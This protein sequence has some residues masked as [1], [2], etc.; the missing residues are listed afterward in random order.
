M[1][2]RPFSGTKLPQDRNKFINHPMGFG[3]HNINLPAGENFSPAADKVAAMAELLRREPF[4]LGIPARDRS[5]W[6]PWRE[7]ALGQHWIA[8]AKKLAAEPGRRVTN[9]L[10]ARCHQGES[11]A[12]YTEVGKEVRERLIA[13]TLAECVDPTGAY[14]PRIEQE[15]GAFRELVTWVNPAHDETGSNFRGETIEVDLSSGQWAALMAA[16]DYLLGDRLSPA[17]RTLVRTEIEKRIFA[18]FRQRIESGKDIYWWVTRTHNWNTV[19]LNCI[20]SCALCLREDHTERA[21]YL[22]LVDDL[23][24]YSNA[25]FEAS[26]FYTEGMSYWVYG[27]GNYITLSELVRA[28][29]D[30]RINWLKE[31]LQNKVARYGLRMEL[32]DGL[33]P[34]FADSQLTYEPVSW[35]THWLNNCQD[36][37]PQRVRSTEEEINAFDQLDKQSLTSILLNMFHTVDGQKSYRTQYDVPER[38]WFE[39]VQF[40]ICRPRKDAP[41]KL[42]ATLQGGHNGVNH[43]HNDLGTFTV[44]VGN[45]YLICDPGLEVYTP[46]TFS[47][48][49]YQSDLL[50]SFGHPVPVVAGQLQA[51]AKDA[52]RAGFGSH[53]FATVLETAFTA[54][55]DR[56]VLD[57]TQAYEV[58]SLRYL[59]R[60]FVYER[61]QDG[62]VEVT[63]KVAFTQPEIFETALITYANWTLME[64]GSLCIF[65]GDLAIQVSVSSAEGTLDFTHAIIAESSTPTRLSW[66]LVQPLQQ[67]VVKLVVRPL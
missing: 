37:N 18:P 5:A 36:D 6:D 34:T 11:R 43:N 45:R 61:T 44:A 63:D 59:H 32:Q 4:H 13:L 60:S 40:L 23:I 58:A 50:N 67:A 52:H 28:A 51:P 7:H 56:V 29:T 9:D 16:I 49:R 30:G 55:R 42:A 1:V 46:R 66:R 15:I 41:V 20:L 62:R 3:D 65:D 22:A 26:G 48:H 27:F 8:E 64:D 39:D 24:R 57:L 19:C 33:F 38:E 47:Q 53:A 25:G 14:L 12:V 35:I 31:P 2:G 21:W 17:I 10:L 54:E